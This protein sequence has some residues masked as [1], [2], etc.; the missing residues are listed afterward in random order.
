MTNDTKSYRE[1]GRAVLLTT[2]MVLSMV[3]MTATL[4]GA[5]VAEA[6][7]DATVQFDN[8][9][10]AQDDSINVDV[11]TNGDA[12]VIL[13]Y[14]DPND[15][16]STKVA[17]INGGA[18]N[19]GASV[20]IGIDEGYPDGLHGA[21]TVHV[22]DD[23]TASSA[24]LSVG[25]VVDETTANAALDADTAV[26]VAEGDATE[27]SVLFEGQVGKG[28][29]GPV[30]DITISDI[31]VNGDA[32]LLLETDFGEGGQYM[33]GS[34]EVSTADDTATITRETDVGD[35]EGTFTV[36]AV[37]TSTLSQNYED[38][39]GEISTSTLNSAIAS[40]DAPL[41]WE[42][43]L[44]K[45]EVSLQS[46]GSTFDG[47]IVADADLP[48][49]PEGAGFYIVTDES[50]TIV[51]ADHGV[52]SASSQIYGTTDGA[53]EHTFYIVAYA[54]QPQP[55]DGIVGAQISDRQKKAVISQSTATIYGAD[56]SVDDQVPDEN[57]VTVDTY[58]DPNDEYVAVIH[59]AESDEILGTS[60]PTTG[61]KSPEVTLDEPLDAGFTDVYAMLHFAEDDG[62]PGDG[63]QRLEAGELV[64]VTDT[65][66]LSETFVEFEDQAINENNE[67]FV[68]T[69]GSGAATLVATYEDSAGDLIVAG[70]ADGA[71]EEQYVNIELEDLGGAPGTHTVHAIDGLNGEEI[72]DPIK[73]ETKNNIITAD[74]ATAYAADV[75]V[76]DAGND[77][78]DGDIVTVN[79]SNLS[80][81]DDY[82]IVIHEATDGELP[83][84][85]S[86]QTLSGSAE[87][88]EI[89][90]E[91]LAE[92]TEVVATLHYDGSPNGEM[93]P[94]AGTSATDNLPTVVSDTAA[95]SLNTPE[96]AIP[97]KALAGMTIWQGQDL[98]VGVFD[99]NQLVSFEE[100][101]TGE[102]LAGGLADDDG[103]VSFDTSDAE[104]LHLLEVDDN[105]GTTHGPVEIKVQETT[106]AFDQATIE[107][108]ESAGLKFVED[109]R[110]ERV[111]ARIRGERDGEAIDADTLAD[112]FDSVDQND[113]ENTVTV[114][115][116]A[117]GDSI[118][119]EIAN[120]ADLG[121][122]NFTVAV[123][124][125]TASDSVTVDVVEPR[126][127]NVSFAENQ[128]E[129]QNGNIAHISVNV[130]NYDDD[131]LYVVVGNEEDVA[132]EEV[133]E[134]SNLGEHNED[135]EL[136]LTYNTY[137]QT[138][139]VED[140][141]AKADAFYTVSGLSDEMLDPAD[142]ELRIA[143]DYDTTEEA[144]I[145]ELDTTFMMLSEHQPISQAPATMLTA[146]AETIEDAED[147]EDA[148]LTETDTIA[149]DDEML[150]KVEAESV[151]GFA[152]E[153]DSVETFGQGPGVVDD[154]LVKVD[155]LENEINVDDAGDYGTWQD[156][157]EATVVKAD[158]DDEELIILIET[159]LLKM[160]KEYQAFVEM[161]EASP[162]YDDYQDTTGAFTIE[163]RTL[164]W[165]D[166]AS[167]APTTANAELNG[168]T[169][170]AAGTE[171]ETLARKAGVFV[172]TQTVEVT[173]D[174]TFTTAWDFSEQ[175]ADQEFTLRATEAF[176]SDN[177][178]QITSTFVEAEQE[179]SELS[180]DFGQDTYEIDQGDAVDIDVTAVAGADGLD[181]DNVTLSLNGEELAS[182]ALTADAGA[183]DGVT[184]TLDTNA[185]D[186]PEGDH[187]L[188][189]GLLD[190]SGEATLTIVVED[191]NGEENGAENGDE[192][193]GDEEN[194]DEENGME[195]GDEE[196]GT[197]NGD[198]ENGNEEPNSDSQPGFGLMVAVLSLLGAALLARRHN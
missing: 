188:E 24:G 135:E 56:I 45:G 19:I 85:G 72:G 83:V 177:Q 55:G 132:Y 22:F 5:A 36:Y 157:F 153:G 15:G 170:V 44:R 21:Y 84:L 9:E 68:N 70:I 65:A 94:T 67:I 179:E 6:A 89:E 134:V 133:I 27:A 155:N 163:E 178:D 183:S 60:A 11:D 166:E 125:T 143:K 40:D 35:N 99:S 81:A 193:N 25:D 49:G 136:V 54:G 14:N 103:T 154:M 172:T 173:D 108:G 151:Y 194:G 121:Q 61:D 46:Q 86:S 182:D 62:S 102:S 78:V 87:D 161:S 31:D 38:S 58:L 184:F 98:H 142:Y 112:I 110:N 140:S 176:D 100:R 197:E 122:Y 92:D 10:L 168:T 186:F 29:E 51:D 39:L 111:D 93:I 198:E 17:G 131:N 116:L 189:V 59:D 106:F 158:Q 164:G 196:N 79:S 34:T 2:I 33:R 42:S 180:V 147:L 117:V 53:G 138:W 144:L 192:E 118:D 8:Q 107:Q 149:A 80:P 64:D 96:N 141:D 20:N 174:G 120:D 119:A 30:E 129:V 32:T 13:T 191:E 181:A 167:E 52:S 71:N 18:N 76:E 185:E 12:T 124:D 152:F 48:S 150:I 1:T 7:T 88:V 139:G 146:P 101:A 3:A 113:D 105:A 115:D 160:N 195:N 127:T 37:P 4:P 104:G 50:G 77:Q 47:T 73:S 169:N 75:N 165:S 156:D 69:A 16:D 26:V 128:Y 28:S 91:P 162:L 130:D 23:K 123:A 66:T 175:N 148:T 126:E 57:T 41:V 171:V 137:Y 145:D 190:A 95:V 82:T 90:I 74:T 43:N 63:I 187:D 109:N 114:A 97:K 159:D